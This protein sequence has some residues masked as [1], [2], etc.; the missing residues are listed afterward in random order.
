MIHF[1]KANNN[2][3]V[4]LHELIAMDVKDATCQLKVEHVS[5]EEDDA[6]LEE[7]PDDF[8]D[9]FSNK[10]FLAGLDVVDAWDGASDAK[11]D[12]CDENVEEECVSTN[13]IDGNVSNIIKQEIEETSATQVIEP[14]KVD[15]TKKSPE[16][17]D[18]ERVKAKQ[19]EDIKDLQTLVKQELEVPQKTE[20][21]LKQEQLTSAVNA[22]E[23]PSDSG[24]S[25]K[26]ETSTDSQVN[27]TK[28]KKGNEEKKLNVSL[29]PIDS[30]INKTCTNKKESV[31]SKSSTKTKP[32]GNGSKENSN[33]SVNSSKTASPEDSAPKKVVD[34][35]SKCANTK[36]TSTVKRDSKVKQNVEEKHGTKRQRS[37]SKD[38]LKSDDRKK[39]HIRRD[40]KQKEKEKET[41]KQLETRRDPK[42]RDRDIERDK[43][44]CAKDKE[45]K[46]I[47]EKLRVVETGLVPPGTEM[48]CDMF[49]TKKNDKRTRS[50]SGY[51]PLLSLSPSPKRSCDRRYDRRYSP[52]RK[53]DNLRKTSPLKRVRPFRQSRSIS[54]IRKYSPRRSPFRSR[55]IR[56]SPQRR[57][58]WSRD[59]P[60]R[61]RIRD[62]PPR[63]RTFLE[64]LDEKLAQKRLQ[65]IQQKINGRRAAAAAA[66]A[67]AVSAP[68][69]V[70]APVPAPMPV[71]APIPMPVA[72][73]IVPLMQ[74][75]VQP[76]IMPYNMQ[77]YNHPASVLYDQQYFIGHPTY[78]QPT[79]EPNLYN[80][81]NAQPNS[82]FQQNHNDE[83]EKLFNDDKIKLTDFLCIT[84]R[85]NDEIPANIGNKI[86]VIAQS[87]DA[88]KI[89][90][91][92][93]TPSGRF[94][95][96][97]T[98]NKLADKQE[99][100]SNWSPLRKT[101]VTRLSFITK[102]NERPL[103]TPMSVLLAK[104]GLTSNQ[105]IIEDVDVD[106]VE[107]PPKESMCARMT[108]T[109]PET[110]EKCEQRNQIKYVDVGIQCES[111]GSVDFGCQV[112]EDDF[113]TTARSALQNLIK[114]QSLASLTPA[115]ILASLSEK[116][117]SL[118]ETVSVSRKSDE[119]ITEKP[120]TET[121][122]TRRD[123]DRR[124]P[125]DHSTDRM[126]GRRS[127][128]DEDSR[129]EERWS[130]DNYDTSRNDRRSNSLDWRVEESWYADDPQP[131]M[132]DTR[133][134]REDCY[135]RRYGGDY[136]RPYRRESE[137]WD[138]MSR[139]SGSVTNRYPPPLMQ[140]GSRFN[141]A[142]FN[143]PSHDSFTEDVTPGHF[144][145]AR[146]Y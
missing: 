87:Q 134:S 145:N 24:S 79:P 133:W 119:V 59:S 41:A 82:S 71:T 128:P 31:N 70:P 72:P 23:E 115:Q 98:V 144:F 43:L 58:S 116:A 106:V 32:S 25:K 46:L 105:P 86:K 92:Y 84:S 61:D 38:S 76:Q 100:L 74:Q 126:E 99:V 67:A 34:N 129:M 36:E 121:D 19:N 53:L 68:L 125:R 94:I 81:Y 49:T 77:M 69:P 131:L 63:K 47:S 45:A 51:K 110:C 27:D 13:K 4:I 30:L 1:W 3:K 48:D 39:Q 93:S 89:A 90:T 120:S 101:P 103:R 143:G 17:S 5:D 16:K 35:K 118:K 124:R 2:F 62:S 135:E 75:M 57:R 114:T 54:P 21:N 96:K 14:K 102:K 139:G 113:L 117:E 146:R 111:S 8:F 91:E 44:K 50:P 73:P 56:P 85:A 28:I 29:K 80:Q 15:K 22:E 122:A 9:D 127:I 137:I 112:R 78:A 65:E 108:Q 60:N 107:P 12:V 142:H 123:Y 109:E 10:E 64:E 141:N 55:Y 18:M 20:N 6:G 37:E 97:N 42:K 88:I 132:E 140:R 130:R 104:L 11:E 7:V 66:A 52:D 95:F 138:D 33:R 136:N 26:L 40:V 83:V